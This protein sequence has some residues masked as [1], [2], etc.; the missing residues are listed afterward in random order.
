VYLRSS[1]GGKRAFVD[2]TVFEYFILRQRP[3]SCQHLN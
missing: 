2:E 3:Q 1:R